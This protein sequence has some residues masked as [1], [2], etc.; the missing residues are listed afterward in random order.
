MDRLWRYKFKAVVLAALAVALSA[1]AGGRR[2]HVSVEELDG[3]KSRIEGV[4]RELSDDRAAAAGAVP[5]PVKTFAGGA[6]SLKFEAEGEGRASRYER[7]ID[8][9]KRAEE[10][11]LARAAREAGVNVYSGFQNIM[12][13]SGGGSYQFIGKYINVWSDSLVSYERAGPPVCV[14]DGGAHRCTVRI[15]GEARFKGPPDPDFRLSA[16]LDKP[17]YFDGDEVAL[18]LRLSRDA[19]ITLLNCDEDG[20]VSL[21]FPNR[22]APENFVRAGEVLGIPGD[23]YFRLTASLPAGR[24]ESAEILHVIATRGRPLA[25]PEGFGGDAGGLKD[26]VK[27]LALFERSDWTA[28]VLFYSIKGKK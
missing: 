8:A 9:E 20:G 26:L 27:R 12:Q 5:S 17:A 15:R 14:L 19:Y 4:Q 10:D 11:A 21:V 28:L 3:I 7:L 25:D 22:H 23:R 1:C 6:G 18:R 13:E 2:R 24:P 16:D